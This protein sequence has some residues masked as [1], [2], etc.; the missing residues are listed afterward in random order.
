M[1]PV[2]DNILTRRSVRS[3]RKDQISEK[4]LDTI[5]LAGSYAPSGMGLQSWKFTAIQDPETMQKVNEAMRLTLK[6]LSPETH[7]NYVKL[8]Q[9]AQDE[10][11]N[12]LYEAPT[13][14]IISN[15][16]DNQNSMADCALAIG[17][18]MLAAH[19][20]R[21]GSC[22]LNQLPRLSEMPLIRN[23]MKEL[24]IPE[25]HNIYGSV[26]MGF[27]AEDPRPAVPRNNV[28]H[29]IR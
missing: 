12:F 17:N 10:H 25:N 1:N 11:A 20:L 3:F 7:P 14:I 15:L 8:I 21:I 27:K 5:L 24:S 23:L 26:A 18:M 16:I 22:W 2:M 6:S 4:D 13:Y 28:I 29:I 19:S 9:K